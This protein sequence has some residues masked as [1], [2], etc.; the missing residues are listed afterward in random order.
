MERFNL[1]QKA[2]LFL[3]ACFMILASCGDVGEKE[4]T[5]KL[6]YVPFTVTHVTDNFWR[7]KIERNL[8]VTVPHVLIIMEVLKLLQI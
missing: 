8:A 4:I 2:G 3:I 7:P 6:R 5:D 1:Y